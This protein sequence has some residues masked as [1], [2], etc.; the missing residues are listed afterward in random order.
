MVQKEEKSVKQ[1]I[2]RQKLK[3]GLFTAA[4]LVVSVALLYYLTRKI[5]FHDIARGLS[6]LSFWPVMLLIITT[7]TK[8]GIEIV[9]WARYL[10]MSPTWK[11]STGQLIV[12]HFVGQ[13]L[14][15]V[16]PG[17]Y[18]TVGKVYFVDDR[19]SATL[20]A[21]GIEKFFIIWIALLFAAFSSFFYFSWSGWISAVA[22]I[23][24]LLLPLGIY[25]LHHVIRHDN[26]RG[27]LRSY[28][29]IIP[30][31][32]ALQILY[33]LITVTQYFVV[34]HLFASISWFHTL[35][36]VSLVL[37][38]N[39]IPL[40]YAGLGLRESFAMQIFPALGVAAQH[41][42]LASLLVFFFNTAVPALVGVMIYWGS[43]GRRE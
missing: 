18:G 12:S 20:F 30:G 1:R 19:K 24:V 41:A 4:R 26:W 9:N 28:K 34:L 11:H 38:A 35:I 25:L 10:R 39:I 16:V 7:C 27:M 32:M 22:L 3:K 17:G 37:C 42:V 31:T 36:G 14:R 15:F 5:A 23:G 2:P 13:S 43:R 8:Q 33:M 29:A 6:Q 21:V 40:A